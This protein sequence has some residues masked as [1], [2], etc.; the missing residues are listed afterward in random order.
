MDLVHETFLFTFNMEKAYITCVKQVNIEIDNSLVTC[1]L[2]PILITGKKVSYNNKT[3]IGLRTYKNAFN[4]ILTINTKLQ[5]S[6]TK[7]MNHIEKLN[8]LHSDILT[9]ISD[10]RTQYLKPWV[11][12]VIYISLILIPCL[13]LILC[14]KSYLINKLCCCCK[15]S[16]D[17]QQM[18]F[19]ELKQ[20]EDADPL[21]KMA[22]E[23]KNPIFQLGTS[24][25]SFSTP[26]TKTNESEYVRKAELNLKKHQT[27]KT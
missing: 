24:N 26:Q 20:N 5:S 21:Y 8:K 6:H 13:I 19:N 4:D 25:F 22:N 12:I 3:I 10:Q 15:K 17:E 2:N 1:H 14:C 7:T 11:K 16:N 27:N 9:Q 23:N 18:S